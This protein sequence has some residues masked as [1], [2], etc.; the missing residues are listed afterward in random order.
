M[1]DEKKIIQGGR[2]VCGQAEIYAK[3]CK[4]FIGES[5]TAHERLG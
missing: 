5:V 1:L 3:G 4:Q 2:T